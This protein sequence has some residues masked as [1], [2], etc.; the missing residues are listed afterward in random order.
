MS[1]GIRKHAFHLQWVNPPRLGSTMASWMKSFFS[2]AKARSII[3]LSLPLMRS[4]QLSDGLFSPMEVRTDHL[5]MCT[6]PPGTCPSGMVLHIKNFALH[7]LIS[8]RDHSNVNHISSSILSNACMRPLAYHL[9]AQRHYTD[10]LYKAEE[11]DKVTYW[12]SIHKKR[13]VPKGYHPSHVI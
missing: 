9:I 5:P 2:R 8:P 4:Q 1:W 6:G 10:L 7:G 11:K 13:K 12:A 3:A